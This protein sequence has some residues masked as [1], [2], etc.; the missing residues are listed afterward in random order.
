MSLY[1]NRAST[2]VIRS[3]RAHVIIKVTFRALYSRYMIASPDVVCAYVIRVSPQA[4]FV[5]CQKK[6]HLTR[7]CARFDY[8]EILP[9]IIAPTNQGVAV[10]SIFCRSAL[11]SSFE[12]DNRQVSFC[13]EYEHGRVFRDLFTLI[14]T[15]LDSILCF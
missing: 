13:V 9:T 5:Y 14:Y 11:K 10:S 12:N 6:I 8:S 7:A 2:T 4:R 15:E 1:V 3:L